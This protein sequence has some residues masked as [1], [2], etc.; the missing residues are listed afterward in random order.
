MVPLLLESISRELLFVELNREPG[1]RGQRENAT[2][3]RLPR[4]L[5]PTRSC[6]VLSLSLDVARKRIALDLG[7][8]HDA[9]ALGIERVAAVESAAV[10]PQDEI[11]QSPFLAEGELRPRNA[12]PEFVEQRLALRQLETDDVAIASTSKEQRRPT[13]LRV[14]DHERVAR[15]RCLARIGDLF[16]S[17]A[18]HPGAVVG[19]IVDGGA[20]RDR[21]LEAGRKRLV[22][23]IHVRP[24]RIATARRNL[25]GVQE[26]ALGWTRDVSH[27]RV[28][29]R[30]P[31]AEIAD[32]LAFDL[33]VGDHVDLGELA[34]KWRAVRVRPGRIQLAE[35]PTEGEQLRVG[36]PLAAKAEDE[37][38]E[39]RLLQL[40]EDV[41]SERGREVNPLDFSAEGGSEFANGE[42]GHGATLL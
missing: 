9:P 19:R 11:V 26:G 7:A 1:V 10:V 22:R 21:L 2:A 18:H 38:L 31:V 37:V 41:R 39:P 35:A 42:A 30:L 4:K 20:T 33:H 40:G 28:P 12:R 23:E 5:P 6:P 36:E 16:H 14:Q 3:G 34:Q 27:V 25:E 17:L 24:V 15:T 8:V 13:R 32:R 29:D